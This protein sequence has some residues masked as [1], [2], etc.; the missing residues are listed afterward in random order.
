MR[1]LIK[2]IFEK[3]DFASKLVGAMNDDAFEFGSRYWHFKQLTDMPYDPEND[4]PD[5][6][7]KYNVDEPR[8]LLIDPSVKT[9]RKYRIIRSIYNKPVDNE[10]IMFL[11]NHWGIEYKIIK[12]F[13]EYADRSQLSIEGLNNAVKEA[14]KRCW[15]KSGYIIIQGSST[16]YTLFPFNPKHKSE[17]ISN[18]NAIDIPYK[19]VTEES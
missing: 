3:K 1:E 4:Y 7:L 19:I 17:Y 8:I 2:A 12:P 13:P 10:I 16:R 14:K 6:V 9:Q 18:L 5:C 11:F 15:E